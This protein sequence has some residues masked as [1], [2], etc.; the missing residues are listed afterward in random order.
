MIILNVKM[1]TVQP[2]FPIALAFSG[3]AEEAELTGNELI[4]L[5]AMINLRKAEALIQRQLIGHLT[6]ADSDQRQERDAEVSVY[7]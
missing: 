3:D 6:A 7:S 1:S 4:S 2:L 5:A